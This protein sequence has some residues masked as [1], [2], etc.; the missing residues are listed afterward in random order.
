MV[1]FSRI[2]EEAFGNFSRHEIGGILPL[3]KRRK[4]ISFL[5]GG[6]CWLQDVAES[7]KS[8]FSFRKHHKGISFL[9]GGLV[10]SKMLQ[11]AGKA[12]TKMSRDFSMDP[13]GTGR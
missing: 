11:K 2:S 7:W 1:V 8:C 10:G 9:L 13:E 4:G 12:E 6:F 3:R 5:L